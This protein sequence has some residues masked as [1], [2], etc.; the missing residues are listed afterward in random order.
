MLTV[1]NDRSVPDNQDLIR[2]K[3]SREAV[4]DQYAGAALN[5]RVDRF[6]DLLLRDRIKGGGCCSFPNSFTSSCPLTDSVSL[7][8]PLI[9][10]FAAWDS[11][12]RDH[13][14]FPALLVGSVNSGTITIP[15][16]ARIQFF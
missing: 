2:R 5:D 4:G 9:S 12:V 16:R 15:T 10:S 11:F 8:I 13:L 7:R 6:L 3:D 1:L 14:A